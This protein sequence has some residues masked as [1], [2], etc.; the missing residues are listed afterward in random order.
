MS[1]RWS[2]VSKDQAMLVKHKSSSRKVNDQCLT[3]GALEVRWCKSERT[4]K[5]NSI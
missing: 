4:W 2:N 1:N 3:D 5:E